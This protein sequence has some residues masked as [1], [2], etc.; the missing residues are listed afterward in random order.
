MRN[1][2]KQVILE[3]ARFLRENPSATVNQLAEH[4]GWAENRSVY[5]WLNQ[6]GY[7]GIKDF[8]KAALDRSLPFSETEL[9]KENPLKAY[10]PVIRQINSP[11]HY[12]YADEDFLCQIKTSS[13]AFAYLLQ[14]SKWSPMMLPGDL[15]VIDPA[16][17]PKES[18][19]FLAW[20][21]GLGTH[22]LRKIADN[23]F[24]QDIYL[25]EPIK[26]ANFSFIGSI[27]L[28]Y[29]VTTSKK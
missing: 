24:A 16:V 23:C 21:N 11:N 20:I 8:R 22:I 14:D 29:R 2:G 26:D 28:L 13:K 9:L 4:M 7:T 15:L 3:M 27:I 1:Y 12:E 19:L 6:T 18:S 17:K 10:I 5:Y 25:E